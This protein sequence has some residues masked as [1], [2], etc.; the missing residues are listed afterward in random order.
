MSAS[1]RAPRLTP[2]G[3]CRLTTVALINVGRIVPER[4]RVAQNSSRLPPL[5]HALSFFSEAGKGRS[6][7]IYMLT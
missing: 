2:A 6:G 7:T 5:L 4:L 3:L 1:V